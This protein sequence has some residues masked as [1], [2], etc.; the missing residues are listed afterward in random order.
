M[1]KIGATRDEPHT[2]LR[3]HR[4]EA[5]SGHAEALILGITRPLSDVETVDKQC[6]VD[7]RR[8]IFTV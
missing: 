1:A 2:G 7:I 5:P 8:I 4:L 6:F 3:S